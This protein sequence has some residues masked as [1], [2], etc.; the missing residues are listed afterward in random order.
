MTQTL[1]VLEGLALIALYWIGPMAA[2]GIAYLAWK[3][4]KIRY[5]VGNVR[6]NVPVETYRTKAAARRASME[7]Y[8]E[9]GMS[10]RI[11]RTR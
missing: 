10:F 8:R 6:S 5:H 9:H 2:A 11:T 7:L 3:Q 1:E 4:S